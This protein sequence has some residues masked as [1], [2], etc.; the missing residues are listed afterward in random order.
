M[1][2]LIVAA[3]VKKVQVMRTEI[4]ENQPP[5][6]VSLAKDLATAFVS[7]IVV[8]RGDNDPMKLVL[9]KNEQNEWT[10]ENHFSLHAKKWKVDELL[11]AVAESKG[12]LRSE[13]K[14][15]L[16]DFSI[17]DSQGI[18]IQFFGIPEKE[19]IHLIVSPSRPASEVNFVRLASSSQIMAVSTDLLSTL[20][21]Y[22]KDDKID[23][24]NFGD[25]QLLRFDTTK[26]TKLELRDKAELITLIK[27]ENP[28]DKTTSWSFD[29][30]NPK[31]EIDPN[32]VTNFLSQVVNLYAK[33]ILDPKAEPYG[34]DEKQV[35][36]R[37]SYIKDEKPFQTEL[38]LGRYDETKKSYIL[39]VLPD[40][41]VYEVAESSINSIKK[42][43]QSFLKS[44]PAKS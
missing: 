37:L 29:P 43:K 5:S 13:S 1:V 11:K 23:Y 31:Q 40:K 41:L 19:L 4:Q 28:G 15:V 10:L 17:T 3:F 25:F 9:L 38:Y 12:E 2:I 44:E 14:D 36:L 42:D 22:A 26:V 35:F 32:K 6:A 27:K 20:G 21:I 39:K 7:K 34:L 24:K 8:M 30:A 16:N 18:H 33:E